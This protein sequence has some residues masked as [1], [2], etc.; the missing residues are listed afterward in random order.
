MEPFRVRRALPLDL[1]DILEIEDE[2]FDPAI[3]E[4]RETFLERMETFP[5]GF[6]VLESGGRIAG[7]LCSELWNLAGDPSPA[8]FTLGHS[9]RELHFP[10]GRTLY[11]SSYGIRKDFRS[12]GLGKALFQGFLERARTAFDFD[13]TL[14]LVC[15]TWKEARAIYEA[16]GFIHVFDIQNFFR[17]SD[18]GIYSGA[19][20]RRAVRTARPD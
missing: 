19:V 17:F 8:D 14:L 11:V 18:G 16:E 4:N 15:E 10:R 2:S 5:E 6:V 13:D 3:R 7:Y 12:R 1:D 9:A 20:L